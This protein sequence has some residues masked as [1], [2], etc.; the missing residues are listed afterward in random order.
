MSAPGGALPLPA[1]KAAFDHRPTARGHVV[2]VRRRRAWC[3]LTVAIAVGGAYLHVVRWSPGLTVVYLLLAPTLVGATAATLR[4]ARR[5]EAVLRAYPWR[6]YACSYPPHPSTGPV[7]IAIR[8]DDAYAP[9]LRLTPHPVELE[10]KR[11][12][13]PDTIWFA[14]DPRFGGVVSPVGGHYPVRVVP[15]DLG[16]HVPPGTTE[17][18]A[19]AERAGIQ[20]RGRARQL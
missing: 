8:F 1:L 17:E 19:R 20:H 11:N 9:V 14:G 3:A 7:T 15:Q 18:D 4:Q 5:I 12:P 13:R 16:D 10:H 2:L 6:A